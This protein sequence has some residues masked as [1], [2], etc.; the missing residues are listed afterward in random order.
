MRK[1]ILTGFII[2]AIA[3]ASY[4]V[5]QRVNY[6]YSDDARIAAD[7]IDISSKV[8]GWLIDF[9]VSSG[10]LLQK[11]DVLAVIDSRET[12]LKLQELES[13]ISAMAADYEGRQA[14][15]S[16]VEQQTT[17]ALQAAQSQLSVAEASLAGS[18]SEL[19]FRASEWKRAQAL[20]ERRIIS[21]H[22]Y[23]A[24]KSLFK[25]SQQGRQ[26][27]L[28]SV[29][30]AR[31]KLVEAQ[32]AQSRL[33]VMERHLAR[34]KFEQESQ[35]AELA[36]HRI[37]LQDRTMVSPLKGIVDRIFIDPGEYVQ[38]GRRLLMMHDPDNV[39]VDANIKETEIRRL[40]AGQSVDVSVDAYPDEKFTGVI[41]KIGHAATSQ[42][43]L[44]PST[45]PSGNFT[46]VTQ[47]LTVKIALAQR[48]DLLKPGM[49]VE[50]TIDI[51]DKDKT[52]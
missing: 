2:V 38:P 13:H 47:R 8:S 4:W 29:A 51:R 49:M 30:S 19:E 20:R 27:A 45:N 36:R 11:N 3:A 7:M 41:E 25:K 37:D 1:V 35:V 10:D 31:A 26:A 50:V 28:G 40:K 34:L 44:L 9:P 42:F 18:V 17:G 16:M 52:L 43:S 33:I 39:W 23:E 46:K 21:Q 24:D 15:L 14:E 48:D 5:Y 12:S 6:V 22:D 32:A